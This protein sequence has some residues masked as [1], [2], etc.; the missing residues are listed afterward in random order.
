MMG[1]TRRDPLLFELGN[2]RRSMDRALEEMVL[3]SPQRSLPPMSAPNVHPKAVD[4]TVHEDILAP[5]GD[6]NHEEEHKERT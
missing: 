2:L 6:T 4:V 5:R 1:V 3:R